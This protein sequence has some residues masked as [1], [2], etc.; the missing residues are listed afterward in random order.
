ME[1]W[2]TRSRTTILQHSKYLTVESHVVDLPDGS[3]ISDWPWLVMPD[4]VNVLVE[5][6]D[7]SYL[8]FRQTKYAVEGIS[9]APVGGYC[10]SGEE[11]LTAAQREVLEETG[12]QATE[13][14]HLGSFAADG[15]RGGG[16]GH[17]FLARGA[18]AVATPIADD[19]EEQELVSLT[20]PQIQQALLRGEFK[21]LGWAA[22]VALALLVLNNDT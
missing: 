20:R 4:Y 15:N 19:R 21:V 11:P 2:T 16:V 7:A 13:W 12:Y 10:D 17:M 1:P 14:V 22:N 5:T 9:L 3:S 18:R 6:T 8:C